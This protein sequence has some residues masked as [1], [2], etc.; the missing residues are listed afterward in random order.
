MPI[1]E[2][3]QTGLLQRADQDRRIC[4]CLHLPYDGPLLVDNTDSLIDRDIQ[5]CVPPC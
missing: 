4:A 5:S 2:N 1:R 3:P